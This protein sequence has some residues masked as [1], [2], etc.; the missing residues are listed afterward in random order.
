MLFNFIFR[1][2][3]LLNVMKSVTKNK[4]SIF[5]TM[6]F[7][8][9]LVYLFSIVGFLF[10]RDDFMIEAVNLAPNDMLE[11]DSEDGSCSADQISCNSKT[12]MIE[13]EGTKERYCDSLGMCLGMVSHKM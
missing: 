4:R 1:E 9:I 3:T 11:V 2:E 6:L 13:P 10:F 8:V 5:L 12:Q 7:A